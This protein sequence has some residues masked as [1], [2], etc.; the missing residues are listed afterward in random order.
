MVDY[1]SIPYKVSIDSTV[2]IDKEIIEKY[3]W[4]RDFHYSTVKT[5]HMFASGNEREL[6]VPFVIVSDIEDLL[7]IIDA[8]NKSTKYANG[9]VLTR[10]RLEGFDF[11]IEL[12]DG[13]R[14]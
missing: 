14:E 7:D 9:V 13:Y 8:L 6:D 11:H 5:T 3:P 2:W 4:L 12:Y 1:R 10:S